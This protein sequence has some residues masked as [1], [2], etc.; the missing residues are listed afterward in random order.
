MASTGPKL[1]P[2]FPFTKKPTRSTAPPGARGSKNTPA[3]PAKT[4][5]SRPLKTRSTRYGAP[6]AR[7][8][9]K[10]NHG[11]TKFSDESLASK[12]FAK[13]KAFSLREDRFELAG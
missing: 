12:A 10:K 9:A 3:T 8:T 11:G 7:G 5:F 6:L 1:S 4:K 2:T 13:T